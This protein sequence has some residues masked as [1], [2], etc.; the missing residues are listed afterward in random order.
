MCCLAKENERADHARYGM[1]LQTTLLPI[2]KDGRD[3]GVTEIPCLEEK[4]LKSVKTDRG[5]QAGWEMLPTKGVACCHCK[6]I[7]G[8]AN[9]SPP[10]SS[11]RDRIL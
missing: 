7:S 3:S 5:K 10:S 6:K 2:W 4:V 8:A 1:S 9:D 11:G